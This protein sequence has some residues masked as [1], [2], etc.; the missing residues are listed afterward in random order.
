MSL[1]PKRTLGSTLILALGAMIIVTGCST[2]APDTVWPARRPLGRDIHTFAAGT[3]AIAKGT[4]TPG[5]DEPI[6][7]LTLRNA[8]ALSLGR[9]PELAAASWAVRA[10][11]A[12]ALQAGAMPNPEIRIQLG[13]FGGTGE[14]KGT[15]NSDQS[16]RLSQVFELG[17]KAS[18]RRSH[19]QLEAA[20]SG[21]D[22]E[23]ARLE[24]F[25]E[26]TK[27]F[28]AVLAAQK[29]LAAAQE[30]HDQAEYVMS[31]V[32]NRVAVGIGSS[33]EAHEA[34]IR[35]VNSQV[36]FERASRTLTAT[37]GMLAGFWGDEA[38]AFQ[39][40]MGELEDLGENEPPSLTQ[41]LA[42]IAVNPDVARW[43]T[44]VRMRNAAIELEKAGAIP[45]L[46][47]LVTARR[48]EDT[49]DYGCTVA[50]EMSLPIFDRNAGSVRQAR[51]NRAKAA[52]QRRAATMKSATALR[53]AHLLLTTA[54]QEAILLKSISV[55][56]A[57]KAV[58]SVRAVLDAGRV[59]DIDLLKALRTL[60]REKTNYI[61]ALETYHTAAADIERL[62]GKPLDAVNPP[63]R[64]Q[65]DVPD[66]DDAPADEGQ[67][68]GE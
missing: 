57:Q 38:P 43:K 59:T 27:A 8:L 44:E 63:A 54:Y 46:R 34:R 15:D 47:A 39:Q 31:S 21:W 50:L 16:I 37:R 49:G 30:M 48:L 12:R 40:A 18:K 53:R 11:E 60:F 61:A 58:D 19:A 45:D 56:A 13:D 68:S 17:A 66:A 3:D 33:L 65:A 14:L 5:A 4:D 35:L 23:T 24:V 7:E 28:V 25:A 62:I 29:Q 36:D 1:E 2:S 64:P 26:T 42:C 20:L 41:L 51:L 6:G 67:D 9:N 32:A 10:G 55:P 52:C 22:Y